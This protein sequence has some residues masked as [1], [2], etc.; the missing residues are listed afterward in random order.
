MS[1]LVFDGDEVARAA[2]DMDQVFRGHDLLQGRE[3]ARIPGL[4]AVAITIRGGVEEF[5]YFCVILHG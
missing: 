1:E 4:V 2:V 5:L 3:T